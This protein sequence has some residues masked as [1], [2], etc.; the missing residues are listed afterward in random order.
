MK[1]IAVALAEFGIRVVLM[2]VILPIVWTIASLFY[3][4]SGDAFK[5]KGC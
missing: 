5:F 1:Q 2:V 3:V 4:L